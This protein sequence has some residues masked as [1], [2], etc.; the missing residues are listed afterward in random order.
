[1][2]YIPAF[3]A[4]NI[5]A[6]TLIILFKIPILIVFAIE[7]TF[8]IIAYKVIFKIKIKFKS[9]NNYKYDLH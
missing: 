1:M 5:T 7:Q 4:L 3:L 2:I 9:Y 8:F 6:L